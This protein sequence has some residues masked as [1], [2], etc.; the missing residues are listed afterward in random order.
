MFGAFAYG[1]FAYGQGVA[2]G[3]SLSADA[4]FAVAANA[5]LTAGLAVAADATLAVSTTAAAALGLPLAASATIAFSA[6]GNKLPAPAILI[7]V[8][9]AGAARVRFPSISI[10]DVLGAQPNTASLTFE[11]NE[12][13]TGSAIQIGYQSLAPADILFSGEVQNSTRTYESKPAIVSWPASLIDQT[14]AANKRRPI[15]R[16]ENVSITTIAQQLISTY[17]PGFTSG[18]VQAGLPA[19]T[20]NF[21]GSEPLVSCLNALATLCEG[22]CKV[23]YQRIVHL[24]V[25]PEPNVPPPDP[26]D[27]THPPLNTPPIAFELDLSQVRTRVY[28]MG[29]GEPVLADIPAA[30]ALWTLPVKDQSMFN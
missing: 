29:H 18:G 17:A 27:P 12:V 8:N 15:A 24:F 28:G 22:R 10:H 21:D 13:P 19:T 16:Y 2:P 3:A 26:L 7:I 5:T 25:P 4:R 9:G 20:I 30:A 1:S 23:D 14:F 6:E 11:G